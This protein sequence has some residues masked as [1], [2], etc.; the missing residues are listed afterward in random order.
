MQFDYLGR[1]QDW[2]RSQCNGDWEHEYGIS[3]ET[4]DNPGWHLRIDLADTPLDKKNFEPI[5]IEKS[6]TDWFACKVSDHKFEGFG[7]PY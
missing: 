4:L 5:K 3:V 7:G 1:L 6:E 2:Y